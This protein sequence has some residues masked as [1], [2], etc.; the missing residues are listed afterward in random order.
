MKKR[1]VCLLY[2]L[3][4]MNL[5]CMTSAKASTLRVA[6]ASLPPD[7]EQF[8]IESEFRARYPDVEI[9]WQ[10]DSG[11]IK[12]AMLFQDSAVDIYFV[13]SRFGDLQNLTG[14]G[15]YVDLSSSALI[16]E[17][18]AL[19]HEKFMPLVTDGTTIY[20]YPW[21][22]TTGPLCSW[23]NDVAEAVSLPRPADQIAIADMLEWDRGVAMLDDPD[24][25]FIY[26]GSNNPY[27]G[28]AFDIYKYRMLA[29]TGVLKYNTKEF[30]ELLA[31][32]D[33]YTTETDPENSP[34][35]VV[36][37]SSGSISGYH[38]QNVQ[39]FLPMTILPTDE[40]VIGAY[41]DCILINPYSEHTE[42]ALALVE[43]MTAYQDELEFAA[44]STVIEPIVD[45]DY[46]EKIAG[47]QQQI[48]Q[49]QAW[50]ATGGDYEQYRDF[51]EDEIARYE[52]QIAAQSQYLL[53]QEAIDYYQQKILPYVFLQ[54]SS[55]YETSD[56]ETEL[57]KTY[58]QYTYG[59]IDGDNFLE[60][61]DNKLMMMAEEQ[62]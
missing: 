41:L 12:Q 38:L 35:Y 29:T 20:A 21:S 13:S 16:A 14:K 1:C 8:R 19:L 32:L 2:L 61:M 45:T 44:M 39:R 50:I 9:V 31:Q 7:D 49:Y 36:C 48:E 51:Y 27:I 6:S 46:D 28:S 17:R 24:Y 15:Y 22:V 56:I 25:A 43:A 10:H 53:T 18:I 11:D 4:L 26:D 42:A 34:R 55:I 37:G 60:K 30:R 33:A 58:S 62:P 57:F 54:G 52:R 40:P 5:L 47:Y 3:F 23:D 59:I